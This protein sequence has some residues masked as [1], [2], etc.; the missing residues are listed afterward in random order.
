MPLYTF[1][2]SHCGHHKEIFRKLAEFDRV[3][4]SHC[5]DAM[6][7][8]IVAPRIVSDIEPYQA[9]GTDIA[10]GKKPMI[11]SRS[12]HRDYLKRNGFVELGN[13]MPKTQK[14]VEPDKNEIGRQI[15]RVMDE[16]GI[17]A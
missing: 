3:G 6:T 17:R 2:C 10:T 16:K 8:V 14:P 7:R 9:M 1:S 11:S 15:K 12:Q 4:P 5:F 13:E